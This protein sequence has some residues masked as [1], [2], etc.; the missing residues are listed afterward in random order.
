MDICEIK[1]S[2]NIKPCDGTTLYPK[3]MP[4][5]KQHM[6][7]LAPANLTWPLYYNC[8]STSTHMQG[9]TSRNRNHDQ[10]QFPWTQG[11]PPVYCP[12]IPSKNMHLELTYLFRHGQLIFTEESQF[13]APVNS[14]LWNPITLLHYFMH[15]LNH[16]HIIS[17]QKFHVLAFLRITK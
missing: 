2:T 12:T 8:I 3:K 16:C 14:K 4:S 15:E 11:L 6:R 7:I 17:W 13:T 5:R 1:S 9:G 10:T